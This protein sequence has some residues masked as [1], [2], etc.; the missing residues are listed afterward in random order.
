MAISLPENKV[1]KLL[2]KDLEY[3]AN[4]YELYKIKGLTLD[5]NILNKD[6]PIYAIIQERLEVPSNGDMNILNKLFNIANL[7]YRFNDRTKED[8]IQTLEKIAENDFINYIDER[9]FLEDII[10][11]KIKGH[12]F[13]NDICKVHLE[14]KANNIKLNDLHQNN[15]G[16]KNGHLT[17]FD[18]S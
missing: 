13:Y 6:Q 12:R 7:I 16:F 10:K 1:L 18:V 4:I 5:I 14:A 17:G 2:N 11:R 9:P 3:I 15:M 8:H